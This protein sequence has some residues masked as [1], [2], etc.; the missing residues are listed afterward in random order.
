MVSHVQ[1]PNKMEGRTLYRG[2]KEVVRAIV[3]KESLSFYWLSCDCLS[4]AELLAGNKKESFFFLLG[5]ALVI[6]CESCP[7]WS[8]NSILIEVS[9]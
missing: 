8:S 5:S 2:E 7:F 4:L 3:S 6:G 9:I 1:V